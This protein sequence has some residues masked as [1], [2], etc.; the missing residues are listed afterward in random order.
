M[1]KEIIFSIFVG[2]ILGI[3]LFIRR[4]KKLK[5]AY[6]REIRNKYQHIQFNNN[7]D[8]ND[9]NTD[10]KEE[11]HHQIAQC[12]RL[13]SLKR[14][15]TTH[16]GYICDLCNKKI[17][18]Y[19]EIWGCRTCNYDV[20]SNCH[21]NK[22]PD[23]LFNPKSLETVQLRAEFSESFA[24]LDTVRDLI[25]RDFIND[26]YKK[27]ISSDDKFINHIKF[28]I[29][30]IFQILVKRI[31]ST[32]WAYFIRN[33][34][35]PPLYEC[36]TLYTDIVNDFR[37]NNPKWDQLTESERDN[38][39]S[40]AICSGTYQWHRGCESNK[41]SLNCLRKWSLRVLE[42]VLDD[43]NFNCQPVR[44][45]CREILTNNIF[46]PIINLVDGYNVN[47]SILSAFIY[48][49]TMNTSDD[50]IEM[51][52]NKENNKEISNVVNDSIFEPIIK[53]NIN[54]ILTKKRNLFG[55]KKK[56]DFHHDID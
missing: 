1:S 22:G 4:Q 48:L 32:N 46:L 25:I 29:D 34:V 44:I 17:S 36:L 54:N 43:T 12:P 49:D 39:I 5:H 38:L 11:E 52:E 15:S 6:I 19:Q 21:N 16:G 40:E 47:Y 9:N 33:K 10:A 2:I 7:N 53:N 28:A 18:L 37:K 8:A 30:G 41:A 27:G 55:N 45:F 23:A 31:S 13:H 20:C 50:I 3:F 42:Q 14:F 51:D 26:W 35:F 24:I 56:E